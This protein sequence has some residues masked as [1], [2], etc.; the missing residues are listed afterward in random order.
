M[1]YTNH[2]VRMIY[3]WKK[4]GGLK[5]GD[6]SYDDVYE[7]H[8]A[9]ETCDKCRVTLTL[10]RSATTKCM[11][12]DHVTGEYRATLCFKCNL[13]NP[14]D[15]HARKNNKS[16]EKYISFENPFT[17]KYQKH[18]RRFK[19]L[20]E[21]IAYKTEY[22]GDDFIDTVPLRKDNKTGE[23]YISFEN[24][25]RFKYGNHWRRFMTLDE[26]ITYKTEYLKTL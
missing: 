5:E 22:L 16:G 25:Y 23:K 21:A 7:I 3:S 10:D 19:T 1:P 14:L 12:H 26:A 2:R 24:P 15:L 8:M 20:D 17:F 11:D 13:A 4:Y 9:K 6:L 18:V